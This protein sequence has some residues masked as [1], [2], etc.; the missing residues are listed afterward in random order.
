[1]ESLALGIWWVLAS[2]ALPVPKPSRCPPAGRG[3]GETCVLILGMLCGGGCRGDLK[4]D[5][6]NSARILV[7]FI[8]LIT[9]AR[10]RDTLVSFKQKNDNIFAFKKEPLGCHNS[11]M[12]RAQVGV[13]KEAKRLALAAFNRRGGTE[14]SKYLVE[15]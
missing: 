8:L 4:K 9:L 10:D 12:Q 7:L 15:N 14:I 2:L 6:V 1:M 5:F 13:A 3:L 11:D